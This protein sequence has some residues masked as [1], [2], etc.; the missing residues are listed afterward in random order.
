MKV[1]VSCGKK[2]IWYL[3]SDYTLQL[4]YY[5]CVVCVIYDLFVYICVIFYL[6]TLYMYMI[7]CF[8][9]FCQCTINAKVNF[10]EMFGICSMILNIKPIHS[11]CIMK[12]NP[13]KDRSSIKNVG[14]M[15]FLYNCN[16]CTQKLQSFEKGS[17]VA[18]CYL[19]LNFNE[20]WYIISTV[21]SEI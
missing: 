20:S 3:H 21:Q 10:I 7:F 9:L 19:R 13:K 12:L 17:G 18:I 8:V 16:K 4:W 5:I 15:F 11:T 1:K 6:N 14:F 2:P